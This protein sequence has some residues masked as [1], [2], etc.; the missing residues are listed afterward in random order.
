MHICKKV[1][2]RSHTLSLHLLLSGI[3]HRIRSGAAVGSFRCLFEG[4]RRDV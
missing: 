1:V 3:A 4:K 2:W